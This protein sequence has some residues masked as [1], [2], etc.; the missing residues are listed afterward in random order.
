VREKEEEEE[1]RQ[2]TG[3]KKRERDSLAELCQVCGS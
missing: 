2:E 3:E 1:K